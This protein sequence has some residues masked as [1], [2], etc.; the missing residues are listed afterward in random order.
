MQ[1]INFPRNFHARTNLV[2]FCLSLLNKAPFERKTTLQGNSKSLLTSKNFLKE[3]PAFYVSFRLFIYPT[4]ILFTDTKQLIK[5]KKKQDTHVWTKLL[6]CVL[7]CHLTCSRNH[8]M[9][10]EIGFAWYQFCVVVVCLL[11][12]Y[13]TQNFNEA[14]LKFFNKLDC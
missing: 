14:L 4:N 5:K 8:S 1:W 7:I 6:F 3:R 13:L 2:I 11:I 10:V 9:S 12:Q